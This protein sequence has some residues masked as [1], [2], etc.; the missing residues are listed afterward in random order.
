MKIL[1][2][3]NSAFTKFVLAAGMGVVLTTAL[4]VRS[5]A[6][7]PERMDFSC[8]LKIMKNN[9][10]EG[11]LFEKTFSSNY[12]PEATGEWSRINENLEIN[13]VDWNLQ[14]GSRWNKQIIRFVRRSPIPG[15]D[16]CVETYESRFSSRPGQMF[17]MQ[18]QPNPIRG[19]DGALGG[20]IVE[21]K[22][23][24]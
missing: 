23:K 12:E 15:C 20:V 9:P 2:V 21:C 13:K 17:S 24:L 18:A 16:I 8:T 1:L 22:P 10:H 19:R 3:K 5:D 14:V 6:A 7:S 11:L 4:P